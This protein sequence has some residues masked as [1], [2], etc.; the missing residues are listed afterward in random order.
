MCSIDPVIVSLMLS[1]V[2]PLELAQDMYEN[3][4]DMERLK[5]S[6]VL[7][8][9]IF[10]QGEPAPVH[11]MEQQLGPSFVAF[12]L[13]NIEHQPGADTEDEIPDSFL[14]MLASYNL[15]FA[16]TATNLVLRGL[17][18]SESAKVFTEKLLLLLNREEDPAASLAPRPDKVNSIHKLV[19]DVFSSD[20]CVQHFY[21]NDIMVS[22]GR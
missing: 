11:Y 2:L 21:T 18:A 5:H 4:G 6:A 19:L 13:D 14:A 15:Q 3:K 1:S 7:L 16:D 22:A 20:G 17:A 12:A 9:F 10:S 8:T